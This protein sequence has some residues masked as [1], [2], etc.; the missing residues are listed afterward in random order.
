MGNRHPPGQ[1]QPADR[2]SEPR[3]LRAQRPRPTRTHHAGDVSADGVELH[4]GNRAGVGDRI[5]TRVNNRGLTTRGGR[6]FVKNGDI[7]TVEERHRGGDLTVR[8]DR[9]GGRVRL[10]SEYVAESVELGYATTTARAQGM[11]VDT[12]HVLVDTNTNRESLYVAATRGRLG[13]RLYVANDDLI[14]IDAER[15]PAPALGARD[16]L[17]EALR[18]ESSERSATEVRREAT[19]RAA[20][21]QRAGESFLRG[22]VGRRPDYIETVKRALGEELAKAV[23]DDAAFPTLSKT[24]ARL[25]EAGRDPGQVLRQAAQRHELDTAASV[26]KVLNHRIELMAEMADVGSGDSPRRSPS[27]PLAARPPQPPTRGAALRT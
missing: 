24:L 22:G 27:A 16:V 6:D 10:P 17:A 14:G 3:R 25:E 13:A 20:E 11:T 18:R 23:I 21:R 9:H 26:A 1:D 8:H 5:V 12:A 19:A 2:V 4:D 15:P 7:W